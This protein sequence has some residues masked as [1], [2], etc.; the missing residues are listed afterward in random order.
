VDLSSWIPM[1]GYG[2]LGLLVLS[3]LGIAFL[4]KGAAD[5]LSWSGAAGFYAV[6][7]ALFVSQLLGFLESGSWAG[8]GLFGF[9]TLMFGSGLVLA[10][11]RTAGALAGGGGG[12][13]HATH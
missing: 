12:D 9:L 1:M 11:W 2:G 8:I 7:L 5:R 4:P 3:W 10:I 6:L 13:D